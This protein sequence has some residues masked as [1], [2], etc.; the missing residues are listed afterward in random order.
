MNSTLYLAFVIAATLLILAPGP[1][2][3]VVVAHGV[4]FGWRRALSTIAGEALAHFAFIFITALGI[5]STLL[6]FAGAFTVLKWAGAVYLVALGVRQWFAAP[7]ALDMDAPASHGAPA[8]LF[9]QGFVV[10]MTNPKAIVFYAAFFT[11]F[12]DPARALAP[13]F[14]LLGA[15]FLTIFVCASA[16][17][18]GLAAR[19]RR[20]FTDP[21]HGRWA[22]RAS[23]S[24]LIG[25]GVGL[26][27]VRRV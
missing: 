10:T 21:R 15:T 14:V 2:V 19:V 18:A 25:A 11:P 23:G 13:Q 26:A 20:W 16:G 7:V 5:S 4:S 1:S 8:A 12:L 9:W 22:N 27:A 6:A 3:A 24:L 17:Y